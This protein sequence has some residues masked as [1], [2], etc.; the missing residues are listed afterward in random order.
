M[1]FFLSYSSKDRKIAEE[2]QLA[3]LGAGHQV[4][5][6][7]NSLPPGG[8][9]HSR[10][11]RGIE[12]S[13]AYIFLIS[14]NSVKDGGYVLTE[15]KFAKEKWPKPWESV[16]PIMIE[17]TD[18]NLIDS[19]LKAITFLEPT[20][21]IAAEV[22]HTLEKLK[23]K[24]QPYINAVSLTSE[25]EGSNISLSVLNRGTHIIRDIEINAIPDD[26]DWFEH[27]HGP[28][29]NLKEMGA[30]QVEIIC[31]IMGG[32]FYAT[33]S[34]LNPNRGFTIATF[35]IRSGDYTKIDFDV[36]WNDHTGM[37]RKSN[38]VVDL[39][40]IDHNIALKPR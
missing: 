19:Y 36:F 22:I 2:I 26:M 25:R 21:N 11:R 27:T 18:Y 40:S 15:L 8:D 23:P 35:E 39:L 31:P 12:E 3:I 20:G 33:I 5:F 32:W 9:Y 1:K 29:P 13:D 16:L 6:D 10:I 38:G 14:P 28:L 7:Q 37:Q 24:P 34:Q 17:R 4:F 30:R